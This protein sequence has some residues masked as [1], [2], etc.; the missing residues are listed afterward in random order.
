MKSIFIL[1]TLSLSLFFIGQADPKPDLPALGQTLA[2]N[3]I[4]AA[5]DVIK[6]A[7]SIGGEIA[8]TCVE[9]SNDAIDNLNECIGYLKKLDKSSIDDLKT[10][11]SAAL[12]NV[13]TCDDE[14][15]SGEPANLKAANK[16]AQDFI[17]AL[18]SLA[19]QL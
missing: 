19:G 1:A 9:T 18:L 15:G 2:K 16:K 4:T 11:A 10:K 3:A 12:T 13:G 14:F 6:I 17:S 5:Q 7:K 8:D